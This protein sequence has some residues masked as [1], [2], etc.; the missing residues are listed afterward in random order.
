MKQ[1]I[2]IITVFA[3]L[4]LSACKTTHTITK[5]IPPAAIT[6][7]RMSQVIEQVQKI[8]PQFKTANISKMSLAL[9]MG[10]RKINVS[11]TCKIRKDSAVFVSIQPF[12]GIELF[13]AELTVDSMRVYDKM[14]HRYYVV[15]YDYF[16]KRFGVNVDFYSLQSLLTAQ[17][18][19]IGKKEIQVDNCKFE[20]L[21]AGQNKIE[22]EN[23]NMLQSSVVSPL[24]I[25]QQVILKAKDSNYQLETDY[26]NFTVVNG[27]NFPQSIS[28]LASNQK[29]KAACEF[30]IL[31]VEFNTD[32]KFSPINPDRFTRGDIDQLLKK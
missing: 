12:L 4:I 5:S 13:K 18:F 30:S 14:N 28:L 9:E 16:N 2:A 8:Q 26:A 19:C 29:T 15:D 10:E 23:N 25:I 22:Y 21:T 6:T 1:R 24:Y 27:V 11:A 31:R 7:N 20:A 3:V 17:F 32:L